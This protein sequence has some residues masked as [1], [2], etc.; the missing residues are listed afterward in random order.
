MTVKEL[1]PRLARYYRL[2][3]LLA[4]WK[5]ALLSARRMFVYRKMVIFHCNLSHLG[6][7]SPSLSQGLTVVRRKSQADLSQEETD[8]ILNYWVKDLKQAQI[9]ERFERGATLWMVKSES[10]TIGFG[11]SIIGT[12]MGPHFFP[13]AENDAYLFDYEIFPDFRNR[14]INA[15]LVNHVLT[16]LGRE[17]AQR[18]YIDAHSWNEAEIRSLGRTHFKKLGEAAEFRIFGR[19]VVIW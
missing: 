3:G 10:L 4:T 12:H 2:H 18:A 15:L 7:E 14:G 13:V 11:W 8:S 6:D 5:K 19:T 9:K 1:K 16:S 17:G